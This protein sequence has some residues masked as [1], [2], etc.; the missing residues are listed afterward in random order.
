MKLQ[1]IGLML[2]S[3]LAAPTFATQLE[4][5]T[6][7]CKRPDTPENMLETTSYKFMP[8]GTIHSEEWLRRSENNQVQLEFKLA[9]NYSF[10]HNGLDY[11]LR[12]INL[13][14]DIVVDKNNVNPFDSDARRDLLG[15]RIFFQPQ[16]ESDTRA[17]FVMRHH[18]TPDQRFTLNCSRQT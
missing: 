16:F 8:D 10:F 6:W 15:Y 7:L 9:V 18:I 17:E 11:V 14:R 13:T 12:P 5:G 3:M 1:I 2:S 4:G